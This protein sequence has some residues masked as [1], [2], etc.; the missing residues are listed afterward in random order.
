MAYPHP[1]AITSARL[2]AAP[3]GEESKQVPGRIFL[4]AGFLLRLREECEGA[5]SGGLSGRRRQCT[6]AV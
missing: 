6:F 2:F 3:K 5:A 1:A 4:N